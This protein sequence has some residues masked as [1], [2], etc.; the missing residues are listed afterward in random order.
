[1]MKNILNTF[2][3]LVVVCSGSIQAGEL[4][5]HAPEQSD[6]GSYILQMDKPEFER[7][8][9]FELYRNIDGSDY[10]LLVTVPLFKA[11]SQLVNQ[12]GVYGY[13][14]RG[15]TEEVAGD[16]SDPVYVEVYSR[17]IKL[18][19]QMKANLQQAD[20]QKARAPELALGVR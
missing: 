6:D 18:L 20:T 9:Q 4:V 3:L 13:K 16:F 11:I 12:N 5:L 10:Q 8:H 14:I 15:V 7:F 17:S 19:S 1:M 2:V